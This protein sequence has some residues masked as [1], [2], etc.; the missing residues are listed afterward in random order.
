MGIYGICRCFAIWSHFVWG[1]NVEVVFGLFHDDK[2]MHTRRWGS[3][4]VHAHML[5]CDQW[6]KK[7]SHILLRKTSVLQYRNTLL[8]VKVPNSKCT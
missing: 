8:Q 3:M 1:C 6:L 7:Y 4:F 5:Q 2:V